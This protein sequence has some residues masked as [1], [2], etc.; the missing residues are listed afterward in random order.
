[1]IYNFLIPNGLSLTAAPLHLPSGSELTVEQADQLHR[2]KQTLFI[3][4]RYPDEFA[5]GHIPGAINIPLNLSRDDLTAILDTI[6]K[7]RLIV[8][9]CSSPS[10]NSSRRLAGYMDF[11]G[12]KNVYIYVAGFEEWK[13]KNKP[14]EKK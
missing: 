4:T 2:Q 7:T 5:E 9:Y 13:N 1:M 11:I 8:T 3:D 6:D 10:C 14:V 12:F